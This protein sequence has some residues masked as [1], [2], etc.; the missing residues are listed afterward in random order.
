M[1]QNLTGRAAKPCEFRFLV[2]LHM[3]ALRVAIE[4]RLENEQ[5]PPLS[6]LLERRL[7]F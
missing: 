5:S 2:A 7:V 4:E 3:A 1:V 6:A